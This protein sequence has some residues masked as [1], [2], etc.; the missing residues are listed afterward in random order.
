MRSMEWP[1]KLQIDKC[2]IFG[3]W[4]SAA[5]CLIYVPFSKKSLGRLMTHYSMQL[6][7]KREKIRWEYFLEAA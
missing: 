2:K 3:S 1:V 6:R 4:V 7:Q 5:I